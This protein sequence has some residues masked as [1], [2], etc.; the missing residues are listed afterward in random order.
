MVLIKINNIDFTLVNKEK[1]SS[2][3]EGKYD[4][5]KNSIALG[6]LG[7]DKELIEKAIPLIFIRNHGIKLGNL[8]LLGE[9][10]QE[11]SFFKGKDDKTLLPDMRDLYLMDGF[12]KRLS[13]DSFSKNYENLYLY[14]I[15]E[16]VLEIDSIVDNRRGSLYLMEG[17]N[18]PIIKGMITEKVEKIFIGNIVDINKVFTVGS[19]P[20]SI[21]EVH[22][23]DGFN[24]PIFKD[25]IPNGIRVNLYN[26]GENSLL[27]ESIPKTTSQLN[28]K[29]GFNQVLSPG[30]ITAGVRNLN[31]HNIG[32]NALVEGSIPNQIE[33]NSIQFHNG[34]NQP[35]SKG[36]ISS[37]VK[38]V[39]FN[40]VGPLSLTVGSIPSTVNDVHFWDDFNLPLTPG[41]I[42][43]GVKYVETN[44][45][46]MV[47]RVGSIPC[48][49]KTLCLRN[50]MNPIEPGIIPNTVESLQMIEYNHKAL[51]IGSLPNTLKELNLSPKHPQNSY[52][53]GIIPDGIEELQISGKLEL[54]VPPVTV[55]SKPS[56]YISPFFPNIIPNTF[57]FLMEVFKFCLSLAT[58]TTTSTAPP[59]NKVQENQD[60]IPLSADKMNSQ[61]SVL[62]IGSIPSSVKKIKLSHGFNHDLPIGII[63]HSVKDLDLFEIKS[64]IEIGSFP[65]SIKNFRFSNRLGLPLPKGMIPEGVEILELSD[66]NENIPLSIPSTVKELT[67][68]HGFNH[69]LVKGIIPCGVEKM[70]IY[71]IGKDALLEESVPDSVKYAF[72][73]FNS[74]QAYSHFFPSLKK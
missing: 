27:P 39:Y 16:Q 6:D 28:F 68:S 1:L 19:I 4:V 49:V 12:N 20:N 8:C 71:D 37:S 64:K 13:R 56:K 25:L 23:T 3:V 29:D 9:F 55:V 52:V 48:S 30:L 34:F 63:P 73:G 74:D 44:T 41:I 67:L 24:Q 65:N 10:N 18:Q 2:I 22:F 21:Q 58:K 26:I 43:D 45:K 66:K 17:F 40:A 36:L 59:T 14:N 72:L 31:F 51:T 42:E 50:I 47:L 57:T 62:L 15:G 35:I 70:S 38:I 60:Q 33:I 69:P 53:P 5:T 11:I 54:Y 61:N 7:E 46:E 32:P